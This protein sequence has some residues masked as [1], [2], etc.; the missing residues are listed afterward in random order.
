MVKA[1]AA[2]NSRESQLPSGQWVALVYL[3]LFGLAETIT[4]LFDVGIGLSLYGGLLLALIVHATEISDRREGSL[5]L[6]LMFVPII[7]LVA[8]SM[9][10]VSLP[11]VYREFF[12]WLPLFAGALLATL[13]LSQPWTELGLNLHWFP[14]QV[15]IG[16]S[17]VVLGCIEY[18][19]LRPSWSAAGFSVPQI[20][21]QSALLVGVV[22][23]TQ[24][25]IFRGLVLHAAKLTLGQPAVIYAALIPTILQIGSRSPAYVLFTFAVAVYFGYVVIATRSLLGVIL[26]HGIANVVSFLTLP[27]ILGFA[28]IHG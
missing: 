27:V 1:R 9:H 28:T 18:V 26:A 24:E 12:T 5:L 7:R 13:M 23:S 14:I 3:V 20:C 16:L 22:A 4:T 15:V 10:P 25:L 19:L 8:L 11:P 17:G 2:G 21:L 6:M